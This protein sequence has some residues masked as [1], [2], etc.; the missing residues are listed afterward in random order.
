MEISQI[1]EVSLIFLDKYISHYNES[2][3]YEGIT[4]LMAFFYG[5]LGFQLCS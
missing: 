4:H 1:S 5:Y 3:D 2:C